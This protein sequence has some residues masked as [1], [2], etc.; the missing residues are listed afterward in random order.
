MRLDL[1]KKPDGVWASFNEHCGEGDGKT[2]EYLTPIPANEARSVLVMR[3]FEFLSTENRLILKNEK[4]GTILR[5]EPDGYRL[6]TRG[7]NELWVVLDQ[8][9]GREVDLSVSGLGRQVGDAFKILPASTY[10]QQKIREKQPAVFRGPLKDREKATQQ[11]LQEGGRVNFEHFV[12]DWF[13]IKGEDDSPLPCDEKH[14]KLFLDQKDAQFFGIFVSNRASAIR[15][16][17]I[18]SHETDSSD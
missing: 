8:P 10:L 9:L 1:N 5:D 13:G 7:E 18:R 3:D 17:Q 2:T 15:A 6:E 14:K 16:E 4:D 12:V 11:D